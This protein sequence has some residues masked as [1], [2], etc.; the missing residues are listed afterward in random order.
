[1]FVYE[2]PALV[3]V[4]VMA[5]LILGYGRAQLVWLFRAVRI[6]AVRA[7]DEPL[8]HAMAKRHRELRPLLLMAPIAKL[9]LT[10]H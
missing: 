7:L 4:A 8:V 6:M 9:R 5:D 3:D 1:M 2:W 10:L